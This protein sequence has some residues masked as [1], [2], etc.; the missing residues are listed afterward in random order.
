MQTFPDNV[1]FVIEY[2]PPSSTKPYKMTLESFEAVEEFVHNVYEMENGVVQIQVVDDSILLVPAQYDG[3]SIEHFHQ[4][5]GNILV[6]G[7]LTFDATP[8]ESQ[9]KGF[10]YQVMVELDRDHPDFENIFNH[11]TKIK[12]VI[13]HEYD[14]VF[15]FHSF[16]QVLTSV[17]KIES[18]IGKSPIK[19][20]ISTL[21]C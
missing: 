6:I 3:E 5:V 12:G 21:L 7:K 14:I 11:I 10:R 18:T 2:C 9:P 19:N 20:I 13:R 1:Q 16:E 17:D 4:R 15:E 8:T